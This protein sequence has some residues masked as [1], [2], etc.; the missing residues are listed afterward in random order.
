[1]MTSENSR[2][3]RKMSGVFEVKASG[4]GKFAVVREEGS[5]TLPSCPAIGELA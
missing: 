1:M 2:M 4:L 3:S 5:T